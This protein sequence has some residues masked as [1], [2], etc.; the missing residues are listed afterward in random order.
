MK[1]TPEAALQARNRLVF[2]TPPP[3]LE[4]TVAG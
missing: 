1:A 2:T 3:V 4:F